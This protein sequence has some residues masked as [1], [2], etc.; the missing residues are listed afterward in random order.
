MF[1]PLL[2]SNRV[3]PKPELCKFPENIPEFKCH[4]KIMVN[5]D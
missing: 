1:L 3:P 4:A 2:H 5:N